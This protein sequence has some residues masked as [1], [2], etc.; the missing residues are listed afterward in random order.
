MQTKK[1]KTDRDLLLL[2][3]RV[4]G[5]EIVYWLD[6]CPMVV[7]VGQSTGAASPALTAPFSWNPLTHDGDAFRLAVTAGA[8][9]DFQDVV[10]AGR[11]DKEGGGPRKS[12]A[13]ANP[14]DVVRRRLVAQVAQV[15][16]NLEPVASK[17]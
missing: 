15:A 4:A 2:A 9:V 12:G 14:Y 16:R 17:V 11:T 10:N 1:L 7:Q 13:A 6:D 3:A 8:L 5:L